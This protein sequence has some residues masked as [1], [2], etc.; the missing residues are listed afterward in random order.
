MCVL[1]LAAPPFIDVGATGLAQYTHANSDCSGAPW[2]C[3]YLLTS[4][5]LNGTS[6]RRRK[7]ALLIRVESEMYKVHGRTPSPSVPTLRPDLVQPRC[8]RMFIFLLAR[9]L[10]QLSF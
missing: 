1:T 10:E 4:T 3:G 2:P 7:G 9:K 5:P 8:V 6:A